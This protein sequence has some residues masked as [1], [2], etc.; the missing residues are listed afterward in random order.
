MF[1]NCFV[2]IAPVLCLRSGNTASPHIMLSLRQLVVDNGKAS[3]F[4]QVLA[5]LVKRKNFFV[6]AGIGLDLLQDADSLYHLWKNAE[7][8][9]EEDEETKLFGL[10]DGIIPV[11]LLDENRRAHGTNLNLTATHLS[12]MTVGCFIKGGATMAETLVRFLERNKLYNPTRVALM[13]SL[14]TSNLLSKNPMRNQISNQF[15]WKFPEDETIFDELLWP[16]K[17]LLRVGTERGY[18]NEILTLL[19]N[20]VPDELRNR[21]P[22]DTKEEQNTASFNLTLT[23][24]AIRLILESDPVALDILM[25]FIDDQSQENFWQSLD[26]RTKLALFLM[27]IDS[28]F[29]F[30][31]HPDSRLWARGELDSCFREKS[32]LPT[33]WLQDLSVA[34][35]RNASCDLDDLRITECEDRLLKSQQS[36]SSDTTSVTGTNVPSQVLTDFE[37]SP[38]ELKDN[39]MR[40]MQ[41]EIERTRNALLPSTELWHGIDY[42]L[43]LPTLLLLENRHAHWLPPSLSPSSKNSSSSEESF[44]STQTLLDAVCYLAGRTPSLSGSSTSARTSVVPRDQRDDDPILFVEFDGKSAMMQCYQ[45]NNVVAGAYLVGGKNGFIL[46]VCD[47]LNRGIG[48]PIPDA[49]SFL[50]D[51]RLNL[52]IIEESKTETTSFQ[53]TDGHTKLLLLL[54]ETVLR[55]Q[56]F[57]D[58]DH[59][60][61]RGQVDPVFA[62]RSILRA[63]LSLSL[64]DKAAAS[65]WLGDWLKDRLEIRR[66]S[67]ASC[68]SDTTNSETPRSKSSTAQTSDTEDNSKNSARYRAKDPKPSRYGLACASLVRSLLWPNNKP[69]PKDA[70]YGHQIPSSLDSIPL[71][72]TMKFEKK[73]II[74]LCQSCL[75]LVESA[76]PAVV[77]EIQI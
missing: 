64:D 69:T 77:R 70:F 15:N 71:A 31:R 24:K 19:N 59:V 60:R 2:L 50:L 56:T 17:C 36:E 42:D 54:D 11:R 76:P 63:W 52:K 67:S 10:L 30:L 37:E 45:A 9:D 13:L 8:I 58:F 49:E 4:Q 6:A 5:W 20:T 14:I 65:N 73:L 43:L 26:H 51:D 21:Y 33:I 55:I 29:P 1:G 72:A 27:N 39:P 25:S 32:N 28:S 40:K 66:V 16:I 44:V 57:G 7:M 46:H 62:A 38:S 3:P 12:E 41:V 34:C 18:L 53:L 75:G 23:K 22:E 74:E 35:L 48:I 68:P 47:V 61:N